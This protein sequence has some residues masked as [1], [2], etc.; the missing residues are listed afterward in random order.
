MMN[1]PFFSCG[2]IQTLHII[3][4]PIFADDDDDEIALKTTPIN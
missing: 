3:F 1:G 4:L 2:R